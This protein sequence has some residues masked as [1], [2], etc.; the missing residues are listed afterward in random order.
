MGFGGYKTTY[1]FDGF[2]SEC[3]LGY[4]KDFQFL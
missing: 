2:T 3:A 4:M 1:I